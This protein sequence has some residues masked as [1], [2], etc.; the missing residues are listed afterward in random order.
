MFKVYAVWKHGG[1]S[2]HHLLDTCQTQEDAAHIARCATGGSAEYAYSED[3]NG[4][5]LVY[6]RPPTYDPQ[7]LTAEQMRQL[8]ER[9]VFD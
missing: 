3:S 9:S 2:S 6:L 7:P 5:R 4:R 8:K 1:V